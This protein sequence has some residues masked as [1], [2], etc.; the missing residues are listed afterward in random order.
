MTAVKATP[1]IARTNR[2]PACC[3][4]ESFVAIVLVMAIPFLSPGHNVVKRLSSAKCTS[5]FLE[6]GYFAYDGLGRFLVH[7]LQPIAVHS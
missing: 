7:A 6:G 2:R 3:D 5:D 4:R 1:T